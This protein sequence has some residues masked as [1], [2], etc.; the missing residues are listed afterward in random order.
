MGAVANAQ[1]GSHQ[2]CPVCE[3]SGE[4]E[5]KVN[6]SPY[7]FI[8]PRQVIA[9]ALGQVSIGIQSPA[10]FDFEWWDT[11]AVYTSNATGASDVKLEVGSETLMNTNAPGGANVN[12]VDI[13]NWAGTAQ[14]PY[15][16]RYPWLLPKSTQLLLTLTDTTNAVNN[17]IQVVLRGFALHAA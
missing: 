5:P 4:T 12:G 8:F 6:R 1:D 16:R 11:V 7:D 10:A 13:R 2:T 9:A 15:S 14:L 3:G 17:T